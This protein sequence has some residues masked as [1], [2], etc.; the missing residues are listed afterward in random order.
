MDFKQLTSSKLLYIGVFL[1]IVVLVVVLYFIFSKPAKRSEDNSGGNKSA[2][3]LFFYVDWCPHCKTAKPVWES[4]KRTY[5]TDK[6]NDCRI[7]FTEVNCTKETKEI[8]ELM[9]KFNIEGYPTFK[10]VK[11]DKIYEFDAKPTEDSLISFMTRFV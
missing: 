2:E 4:L 10:L 8:E 7:I 1:A 5:E 3:L 11:D 9:D 6:I